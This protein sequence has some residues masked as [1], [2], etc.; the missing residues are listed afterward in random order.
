MTAEGERI[1]KLEEQVRGVR[2]DI[3]ELVAESTRARKRLHDLEGVAQAFMDA[4]AVNRRQEER[5]YQRLGIRIQV[6]T[7]VV[8]MAAVVAPIV[9]VLLTGK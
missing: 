2:R 7:I 3:G 8:G 9:T 6:L 5:Q 1:A 4:Q